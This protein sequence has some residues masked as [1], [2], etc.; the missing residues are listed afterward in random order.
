MELNDFRWSALARYHDAALEGAVILLSLARCPVH[1]HFDQR[2]SSITS[3]RSNIRIMT[4]IHGFCQNARKAI[5]I[6]GIID[7]KIKQCAYSLKLSRAGESIKGSLRDIIT[8]TDQNFMWIVGRIIHS[9]HLIIRSENKLL[10]AT[11]TRI[12][13]ESCNKSLIFGSDNDNVSLLA[14]GHE[15]STEQSHCIDIEDFIACYVDGLRMRIEDAIKALRPQVPCVA[16][17]P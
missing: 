2:F 9:V 7:N 3:V 16:N 12:Y 11:Q 6:S 13:S 1:S 17:G 14:G 8:I 4:E 15:I 10:D 5:E